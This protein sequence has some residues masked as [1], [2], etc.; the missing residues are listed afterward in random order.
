MY[1]LGN[2]TF[3]VQNSKVSASQTFLLSDS[4]LVDV[5]CAL[6]F[7]S[8]TIIGVFAFASISLTSS[9]GEEL[10]TVNML[11]LGYF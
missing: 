1:F 9:E 10:S 7:N 2:M 11:T 6:R 5:L 3:L 4:H 8:K